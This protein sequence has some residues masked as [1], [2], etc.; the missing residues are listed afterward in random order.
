[1]KIMK[2]PHFQ[3]CLSAKF[4]SNYLPSGNWQSNLFSMHELLGNS[5]I[6]VHA[7]S[8]EDK[9]WLDRQFSVSMTSPYSIH[10]HAIDEFLIKNQF[11]IRFPPTLSRSSFPRLPLSFMLCFSQSYIRTANYVKFKNATYPTLSI[12]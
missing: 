9:R 6:D 12:L 3:L 5:Y 11:V 8:T 4:A 10:Q 1:M 2:F 7:H